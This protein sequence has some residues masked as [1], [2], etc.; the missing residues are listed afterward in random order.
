MDVFGFK[1]KNNWK[2]QTKL[3]GGAQLMMMAFVFP[4]KKY[5]HVIRP[6]SSAYNSFP[7]GH[8]AQAFLAATFFY[9]EYGK[10][11][12]WV[13]VGMFTLASGIGVFRILNNR[14]WVSDVLAGAGL[15]ILSVEI[16]YLLLNPKNKLAKFIPDV[17]VPSYKNGA[18]ICT[19]NYTF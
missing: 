7:S 8:T 13:S 17:I 9:K 12:P 18:F 6:D 10:K 15:G 19:A 16:S 4:I 1:G 2:Q 5:S 11:Y 14:H 3:L